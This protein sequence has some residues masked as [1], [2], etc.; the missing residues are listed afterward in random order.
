MWRSYKQLYVFPQ[1]LE[2]LPRLF[3]SK[4]QHI[5]SFHQNVSP[6]FINYGKPRCV[7]KPFSSRLSGQNWNIAPPPHPKFQILFCKILRNKLHS[8][9]VLPKR[10]HLNDNITGFPPQI[11][12]LKEKFILPSVGLGVGALKTTMAT[13]AK[14]QFNYRFNKQNNNSSRAAHYVYISLPS[15]HVD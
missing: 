12:K 1:I 9:K 8:A 3:S 14:K 7:I 10:F 11:K 2:S 4:L 13:R 15:T 5:W 6:G